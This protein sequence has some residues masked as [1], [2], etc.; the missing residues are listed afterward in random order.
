MSRHTDQPRTYV[1]FPLRCSVMTTSATNN[2][3]TSV[4]H[5]PAHYR[6]TALGTHVVIPAHCPSGKHALTTDTCRIYE[7]DY[8]LRATCDLCVQTGRPDHAWSLT[9]DGREILSAELDGQPYTGRPDFTGRPTSK[10]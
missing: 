2:T 3:T 8:V 6:S 10:P 7:A 4:A 9:T 5:G 1:R